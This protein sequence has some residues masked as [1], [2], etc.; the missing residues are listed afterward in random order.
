DGQPG[1]GILNTGSLTIARVIVKE[2]HTGKGG[3]GASIC[4]DPNSC[5]PSGGTGGNGAGISSNGT[6]TV[7]AST[8]IANAT[9]AGG[10]AGACNGNPNC[11]AT[12]GNAGNG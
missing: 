3:N 6:L 1:A 4:Q 7:N 5:G 11:F 9:G 8:F 2:N 10:A 12:R